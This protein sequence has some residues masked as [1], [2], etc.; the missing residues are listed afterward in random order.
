MGTLL[1]PLMP[2][3][4]LP[5]QLLRALPV[6]G[7][8]CWNL[9]PCPSV[10][11]RAPLCP[12]EPLRAPPCPHVDA[13]H[14]GKRRILLLLTSLLLGFPDALWSGPT[15]SICVTGEEAETQSG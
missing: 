1:L 9:P 11:L 4:P 2:R 8:G 14:P 13:S 6:S 7:S 10:P 12:S 5:R 15:L 3:E